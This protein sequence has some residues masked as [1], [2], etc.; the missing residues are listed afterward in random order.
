MASASMNLDGGSSSSPTPP[1][2]IDGTG[3]ASTVPLLIKNGKQYSGVEIQITGNQPSGVFLIDNGGVT[4]GRVGLAANANDFIAGTAVSDVVIAG[5][6]AKKIH[7]GASGGSAP[8]MSFDLSAAQSATLG[9]GA[10]L[11]LDSS[12]SSTSLALQVAGD[13]NTGLGQSTDGADSLRIVVGGG[14]LVRFN[15]PGASTAISCFGNLG[16][17]TGKVVKIDSSTSTSSVA[18]QIGGV[19]PD[20]NTGVG[21]IGGADTLSLVTGGVEALR[22]ASSGDAIFTGPK[23][24]FA[25]NSTNTANFSNVNVN[26]ASNASR[27]FFIAPGSTSAISQ[28]GVSLASS[29]G[30]YSSVGSLLAIGTTNGSDVL[31]GSNNVERARI[32]SAGDVVIGSGNTAQTSLAT[33]AT[34]GFLRL[35]G[36]AGVPTGAAVDGAVVVDTDGSKLYVRIG[37]SW[38]AMN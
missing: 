8:I 24:D 31:Q 18:L 3:L 32:K 27:G 34:D 2:V 22:V 9:S 14:E 15:V 6:N 20:P 16:M 25:L 35:P 28:F 10:K 4:R 30:L 38:V 26:S 21:Q 12:Q 17:V 13:P 5:D 29:V 36:C 33:N 11:I 19:S 7:L 37:G 1:V 23:V